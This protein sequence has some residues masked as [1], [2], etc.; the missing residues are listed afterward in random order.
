M[1]GKIRKVSD[2]IDDRTGIISLIHKAVTHVV[3]QDARWWYVFGSAALLCFSSQIITGMSLLFYY[4]PSTDQAYE[5]L[6]Y[7]HTKSFF[8]STLRSLHFFGGSAMIGL[9]FV[10]LAQVYLHAAYKYPRELNWVSGVF[11]LL[12]TI[13]MG[14]SGQILRW[15]ANAIWSLLVGAEQAA[16]VPYIGRSMA[17][18]VLGGDILTDRSLSQFFVIHVFIL[19]GALIS[20]IGLHLW[21]VFKNGISEMPKRDEKVIVSSYRQQYKKRLSK[22]GVPFW[23]MAAWRDLVFGL[24]VAITVIILSLWVGA[25]ELIEAP[26]QSMISVNP[27]PDWYLRWYFAILSMIPASAETY[28]ILGFPVLAITTLMVIPFISPQGNRHPYD[29]P[30]SVALLSLTF[31]SFIALTIYGYLEP[32]SPRFKTQPL[33]AQWVSAD[34]KSA[35]NGAHLFYEK[36]CQSCHT[37]HGQGGLRGPNLTEVALRLNGDDLRLRINNGG[38][39]MPAYASTL[40]NSELHD[41]VQFLLTCN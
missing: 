41:L 7:I 33:K 1:S 10:H 9:V 22:T 39:N 37:I 40:T 21:L 3:P 14:F 6:Q 12:F 28:I 34:N 27:A 25:P 13:A 17:H 36:K 32:W 16:R 11:L 29:R 38:T 30:W 24:G 8:G 4:I 15:D 23:P 31:V 26:N 35:L 20:F 18:F 19:P 2:Y 5:S